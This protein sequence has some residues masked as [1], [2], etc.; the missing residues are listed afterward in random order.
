MIL[1]YGVLIG[2]VSL[3]M[4]SS[5]GIHF[6]HVLEEATARHIVETI[7]T[8][9]LSIFLFALSRRSAPTKLKP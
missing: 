7:G 2:L 8:G 1:K 6:V 9:I 3:A 4:A 5:M